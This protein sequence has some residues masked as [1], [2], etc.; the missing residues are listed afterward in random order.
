ELANDDYSIM[1]NYGTFAHT[2]HFKDPR[3]INVKDRLQ[4]ILPDS[5]IRLG[6]TNQIL[7]GFEDKGIGI[8]EIKSILNNH[9]NYPDSICRHGESADIPLG[10]RGSSIDT[11]FSVIFELSA[12][13]MH[14]TYGTP[15]ENQYTA[16]TF[17]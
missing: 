1:Y 12:N 4:E 7:S 2:N 17:S 14:L 16:L 15:C 5:H 13:K 9:I 3:L 11:I 8:N 10:K 6:V